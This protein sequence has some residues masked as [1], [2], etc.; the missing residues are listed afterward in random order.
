MDSVPTYLFVPLADDGF[1]I[2]SSWFAADDVRQWV[3]P[4]TR[5][6]FEYV[7]NTA[8]CHAWLV[9]A[10]DGSA[11]GHVQLDEEADGRASIGL[12][13]KPEARSQHHGQNILRALLARP[14]IAHLHT[15]EARVQPDNVASRRCCLAAGF[16]QADASPGEDGFLKLVYNR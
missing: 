15:L 7:R 6:W 1:Q 16:V 13:V 8:G 9:C 11:V 14:E 2:Y 3:T 4:P 12:M 10:N 5:Q